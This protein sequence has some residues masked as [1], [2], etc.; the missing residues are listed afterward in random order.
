MRMHRPILF[1]YAHAQVNFV[2]ARAGLFVMRRRRSF[3]YAQ[4]QVNFTCAGADQFCMRTHKST[5]DAQA[6]V[7]FVCAGGGPFWLRKRRSI[8]YAQA[9]VHFVCARASHSYVF[10][11]I[12]FVYSILKEVLSLMFFTSPIFFAEHAISLSIYIFLMKLYLLQ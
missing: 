6:Q 11:R 7:I 3:W 8:W 12:K 4:A 2:C 10:M 5:L 1:W 9:Q